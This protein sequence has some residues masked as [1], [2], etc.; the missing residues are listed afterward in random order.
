MAVLLPLALVC[1]SFSKSTKSDRD[2]RALAN[3]GSAYSP[4][5]RRHDTP[6][7]S[8]GS[9]RANRQACDAVWAASTHACNS[10]GASPHV[11]APCKQALN[12]AS[13]NPCAATTKAVALLNF[14]SG[15]LA[16]AAATF[17]RRAVGHVLH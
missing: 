15:V 10:A 3:L 7:R 12:L 4:E 8:M 17:H 5:P 13:P 6:P 11:A 9:S 16:A 2:R 14:A 1:E